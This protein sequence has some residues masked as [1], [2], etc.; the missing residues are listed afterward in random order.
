MIRHLDASE[1]AAFVT[2]ASL[3]LRG[4]VLVAPLETGYVFVADAFSTS[5]TAGIRTVRGLSADTALSV[6]IGR[7][8]TLAGI[9]YGVPASVVAALPAHWPGALTLVV[10]PQPSLTWGVGRTRFPVRMPLHPAA[11]R[12][13]RDVGPLAVSPVLDSTGA[14]L[15]DLT[16]LDPPKLVAAVLDAGTLRLHPASTVVDITASPAAVLRAGP[17]EVTAFVTDINDAP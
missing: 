8:E 9:A 11:L 1:D 12:L 14:P 5:A 13:A 17:V 10:R 6:L 3:L 7:R 16:T 2:A 15:R 4:R